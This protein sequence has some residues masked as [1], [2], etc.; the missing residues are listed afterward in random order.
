MNEHH[1][2]RK[3]HDV[4]HKKNAPTWCISMYIILTGLK[5][6]RGIKNVTL[7]AGK[8]HGCR[9]LLGRVIT[10]LLSLDLTSDLSFTT[11]NLHHSFFAPR[12]L[13]QLRRE[14]ILQTQ[15]KLNNNFNCGAHRAG[16][17]FSQSTRSGHL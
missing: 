13:A 14:L 1:I 6:T 4:T 3:S 11:F 15:R 2:I 10:L 7:K 5:Q 12:Y 17:Y 9:G 8:I 16:K